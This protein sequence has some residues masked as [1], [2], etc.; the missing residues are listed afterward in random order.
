VSLAIPPCASWARDRL[1]LLTSGFVELNLVVDRVFAS[2]LGPGFISA[3]AYASRAVMTVV[4]VFMIPLGRMLLPTL[5][6]LAAR[7]RYERMRGL[8][9]K[10]VIG[11]AFLMVPL[12]AFMVAFRTELLGI[13]FQRGAFDGAAVDATA[14]A[15]AFYALG[16]IPFL[17]TPLLS[18]AFFALQDSATPLRI[19]AVCVVANAG[20]DALL[21]LGLGHGGI[22]LATSLVA[23][24]RFF[25]IYLRRRVGSAPRSCWGRPRSR[26]APRSPSGRAGD[27]VL[28]R[29]VMAGALA[30]RRR[31]GDRRRGPSGPASLFNR[32]VVRRSRGS[33]RPHAGR[34]ER[35]AAP[36]CPPHP[37]PSEPPIHVLQ[38]RGRLGWR[39]RHVAS[40]WRA[41]ATAPSPVARS[42]DGSL[43]REARRLNVTVHCLPRRFRGDLG[44]PGDWW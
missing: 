15:L 6:R 14:E 8:L 29:P 19:G 3:L 25:L 32:P 34:P 31:A 4:R 5:T 44:P 42:S 18:G 26:S 35:R 11:L 17:M 30:R 21:M 9:E 16:I 43:A 38:I 24:I 22:A 36:G 39:Q 12:V 41:S 40:C 13:L 27:G 7:E 10:L 23:A 37:E 33:R 28:D 2:L 1:A 20:L